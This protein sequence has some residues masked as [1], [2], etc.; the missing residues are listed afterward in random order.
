[1]AIRKLTE[2]EKLLLI[3]LAEE[4][5][6]VAQNISKVLRF[7]VDGVKIG[8]QETNGERVTSEMNDLL[9]VFKMLVDENVLPMAD[10]NKILAKKEKVEKY[11]DYS[12]KII[13]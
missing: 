3:Q 12:L 10:N 6:E 8:L 5:N 7:G 11:M 4:C 13:R 1:M 9:G 2:R